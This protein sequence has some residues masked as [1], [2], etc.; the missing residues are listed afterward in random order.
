MSQPSDIMAAAALE[1][2]EASWRVFPL[3]TAGKVP[4]IAGGRGLLDATDDPDEVQRLWRDRPTANI[5]VVVPDHLL[6]LDVDPRHGGDEVLRAFED[7]LGPLPATLTQDTGGGGWHLVVRH[8]GGQLRSPGP[9][10]DVRV[11]G[12]HYLVA[13][14][15]R[16]RQPPGSGGDGHYRWRD[17]TAPIADLPAWMVDKMRPPKV[18]P[19]DLA[20]SAPGGDRPGDRFNSSSTWSS[21]LEPAGW[22]AVAQRGEVTHWCRPGKRRRGTSAITGGREDLLWVFSTCAAPLEPERGY[23]RFGAWVA[24]VHGGDFSAAARAL[25]EAS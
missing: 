6:V 23:D 8:P 21:I 22:T 12:R 16:V 18:Q 25:R 11:G 1:Y 2:A 3:A 7:R 4:A 5:G 20:R 19:R 13:A 24:L 9:G 10:L 15:S 14:P 17:P